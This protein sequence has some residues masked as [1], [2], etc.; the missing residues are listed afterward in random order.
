MARSKPLKKKKPPKV[1][2]TK[3]QARILN[4]K[5]YGNEPDQQFLDKNSA[6]LVNAFTWYYETVDENQQDVAKQYIIDF[7][8]HSKVSPDQIRAFSR[9]PKVRIILSAGWVCRMLMRGLKLPDDTKKGAMIKI[10]DMLSYAEP[11]KQEH[12]IYKRTVQDRIN[13]K[14][15]NYLGEV[16]YVADQM[17][18]DFNMYE[19]L[20]TAGISSAHMPRII[21]HFSNA[22]KDFIEC[23]RVRKAKKAGKKLHDMDVQ[24]LE[25]YQHLSD[26][27]LKAYILWWD[28]L[29]ADC[30]RYSEI[31]K[32]IVVRKP[33]KPRTVTPEKR[34]SKVKY[35]AED[36]VLNL[37]SIN[38]TKVLG[39][40][41]LWTFNTSNKTLTVYF[42]NSP[43][44]L[45]FNRSSI[46]GYD[47]TKSKAMRIGR[48]TDQKL[49]IVLQG[50]AAQRNKFAETLTADCTDRI[51]ANTVLL[52]V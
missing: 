33:R 39:A 5:N 27:K 9:V 38:P 41:Q 15:S 25:G 17:P 10:K 52:R 13:D 20:K 22:T 3:A 26:N 49:A 37:N 35:K 24:L 29:I 43:K 6:G 34:V 4:A 46:V 47:Q 42:A 21:S 28:R 50:T 31:E 36:T 1:R 44:G 7:M 14:I 23:L 18:P 48:K 51:G 16:E 11:E 32:P 45:D 30:N 40:Q 8:K 12:V 19:H 2:V